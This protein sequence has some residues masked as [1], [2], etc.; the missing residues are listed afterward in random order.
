MDK[1]LNIEKIIVLDQN[2]N[3]QIKMVFDTIDTNATFNNKY[4]SVNENMK[5]IEVEEKDEVKKETTKEEN[6]NETNNDNTSSNKTTSNEEENTNTTNNNQ[7][8]T[9]TKEKTNT[10]ST[11]TI[12]EEAVYPMYLPSGTYLE[13]EEVV[14]TDNGDRTILTFSGESPFI[15][16]E[17][18][19]NKQDEIEIIPVYGEP[20]ILVDT[21]G[22]LS[23]T[24]VNFISNGVE[25]YIASE[26]LTKQEILEVASSLASIPI[27]K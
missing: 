23:D 11:T 15:L 1:N 5:T 3:K 2:G 22:A 21:V 16:V 4:F 6:I 10:E 17:E 12:L 7:P 13:S 8:T 19:V 14:S 27:M 9:D 18:A 20:T 24:S 25:Y 26:S